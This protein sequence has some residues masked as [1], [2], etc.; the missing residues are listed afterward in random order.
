[1]LVKNIG[2][3]LESSE[4]GRSYMQQ[5]A[6]RMKDL[7]NVE[8]Y[9]KRIKFAIQNVLDLR[10][11]GWQERVLKERMKT[12][13]QIRRDAAR[14]QRAQGAGVQ[15]PFAQTEI[16]GQRPSYITAVMQ[17]QEAEAARAQKERERQQ[18][19]RKDDD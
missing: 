14:E 2:A 12:K 4:Q 5:F 11:N 8:S 10:S 6:N 9:T 1:M 16:A 13:D 7:A 3:T 19:E 17:K 18:K 15:N